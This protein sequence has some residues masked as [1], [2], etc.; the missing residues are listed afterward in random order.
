[1]VSLAKGQSIRLALGIRT[2]G[3]TFHDMVSDITAAL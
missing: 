1:V 2:S 3:R